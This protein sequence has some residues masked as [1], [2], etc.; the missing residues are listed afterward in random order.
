MTEILHGDCLKKWD[1]I[2]PAAES[3]G[4][5][6]SSHREEEAMGLQSWPSHFSILLVGTCVTAV[7]ALIS[8]TPRPRER[9]KRR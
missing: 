8:E 3:V 4:R 6:A 5:M 2:L 1:L 7:V 9:L